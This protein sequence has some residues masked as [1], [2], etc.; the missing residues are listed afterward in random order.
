M[1][2][3][4]TL[5]L[6]CLL[7]RAAWAEDLPPPDPGEVETREGTVVFRW[8]AVD[9]A[10][11]YRVQ[12]G[13]TLLFLP[14][15]VDLRTPRPSAEVD[16][17]YLP[18]R[19]YY[20]R[21]WAAPAPGAEG[22][23]SSSRILNLVPQRTAI[24]RRLPPPP[25]RG[26][27]IYKPT[28]PVLDQVYGCRTSAGAASV[29]FRWQ[30]KAWRSRVQVARDEQFQDL[31]ADQTILK[32][33]NDVR[34]TPG[35]YFYRLA[36]YSTKKDRR[37]IWSEVRRFRV[38]NDDVAPLLRI[39]TPP[40]QVFTNQATL[41]IQGATEADATLTLSGRE[42][43]VSERGEFIHEARLR[44]G[45]NELVLTAR[46][47]AGNETRH[48]IIA[49][50]VPEELQRTAL[51]RLVTLQARLNELEALREDLELRA[52]EASLQLMEGRAISPELA[53]ELLSLQKEL[54]SHRV[55]KLALDAELAQ[56]A[57][58]VEGRL[59]VRAPPPPPRKPR[60]R[61]R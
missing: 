60:V 32:R 20:W 23:F 49:V 27:I 15:T 8:S 28:E 24:P 36:Q 26:I 5:T 34:L 14:A 4:A 42:V 29:M 54:K 47:S 3:A 33:G 2:P 48:V 37:L 18:P 16:A 50:M 51:A 13:K 38:E 30:G 1:R 40:S 9:G 31:A 44:P 43:D 11:E 22:Q 59:G 21:V 19:L 10:A 46:D 57:L 55:D 17:G 52:E 41:T 35:T 7:A 39:A 61:R 45:H 12:V 53:D 25:R 58:D 6:C 56:I